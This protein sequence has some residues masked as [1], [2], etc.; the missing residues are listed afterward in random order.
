[1]THVK[2]SLAELQEVMQFHF[3]ISVKHLQLYFEVEVM[4]V[5][6]F[7]IGATR[8]GVGPAVEARLLK[9]NEDCGHGRS[10]SS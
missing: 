4:A 1:M 10:S 7:E 5:I 6:V 2:F 8:S 9:G 3:A